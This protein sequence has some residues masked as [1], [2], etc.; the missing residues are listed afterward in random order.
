MGKVSNQRSENTPLIKRRCR[1]GVK[2]RRKIGWENPGLSSPQGAERRESS[3][4]VVL[5]CFGAI[6][7]IECLGAV[8]CKVG[9]MHDGERFGL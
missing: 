4:S 2:S 9:A 1:M 3:S 5:H 6:E 7:N 8:T